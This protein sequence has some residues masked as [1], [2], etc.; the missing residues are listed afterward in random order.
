MVVTFNYQVRNSGGGRE[1]GRVNAT[2]LIYVHVYVC[3][4]TYILVQN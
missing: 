1:G 3:V 4:Y 2:K